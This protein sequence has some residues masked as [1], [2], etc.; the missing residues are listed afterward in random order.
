M[1]GIHH[2]V[3]EATMRARFPWVWFI[4]QTDEGEEGASNE[5]MGWPVDVQGQSD[6]LVVGQGGSTLHGASG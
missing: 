1:K 6:W 5:E 2:G 4:W 3:G